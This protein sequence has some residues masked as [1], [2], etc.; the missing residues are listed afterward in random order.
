[1]MDISW[2]RSGRPTDTNRWEWGTNQHSHAQ[3]Q[4]NTTFCTF[5]KAGK[6]GTGITKHLAPTNAKICLSWHMWNMCNHDCPQAADHQAHTTAE[7]NAILAW[8]KI[9]LVPNA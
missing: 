5:N 3:P 4:P 7:D 8:A 1:M 6:L 2:S 9:A